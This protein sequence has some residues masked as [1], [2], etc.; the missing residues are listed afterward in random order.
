M[1]DRPPEPPGAGEPPRDDDAQSSAPLP[2][3]GPPPSAGGKATASLV[4]G[5]VGMIAWCLPLIGAPVAIV[6]LTLGFI[7]RHSPKRNRAIA[8]IVLCVI[9]L[10]LSVLN[11]IWGIYL[12]A[13]GQ[14]DPLTG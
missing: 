13:T 8:G 4:L 14:H 10:I 1:Q 9:V 11:A 3:A 2:P 6:G 5:I 12:V 7:D